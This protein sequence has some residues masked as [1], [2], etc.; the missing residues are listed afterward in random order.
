MF[1]NIDNLNFSKKKLKDLKI[2]I[3]QLFHNKLFILYLFINY[4]FFIN[5]ALIKF[6]NR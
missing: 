6:N 1:N 4:K 2:N 5:F 3:L